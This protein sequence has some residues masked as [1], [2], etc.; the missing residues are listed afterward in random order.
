LL[1][2]Q[3]RN[4]TRDFGDGFVEQP[5]VPRVAQVGQGKFEDAR[6]RTFPDHVEPLRMRFAYAARNSRA[7][8]SGEVT[9]LENRL[10]MLN[11]IGTVYTGLA[12]C[13]MNERF[14]PARSPNDAAFRTGVYRARASVCPC[15]RQRYRHAAVGQLGHGSNP[16]E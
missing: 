10:Q 8:G 11:G 13:E 2:A 16:T 6:S 12:I 14:F 7:I 9:D 15:T 1:V 5:V 4:A 3:P